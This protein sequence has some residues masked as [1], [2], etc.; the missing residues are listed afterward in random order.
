MQSEVERI[1]NRAMKAQVHITQTRYVLSSEI[2]PTIVFFVLYHFHKILWLTPAWLL[3]KN[4]K[5]NVYHQFPWGSSYR[6]LFQNTNWSMSSK[7]EFAWIFVI[8]YLKWKQRKCLHRKDEEPTTKIRHHMIWSHTRVL[9]PLNIQGIISIWSAKNGDEFPSCL[10]PSSCTIG[11]DPLTCFPN[12]SPINRSKLITFVG[13][14]RERSYGLQ[15][16]HAIF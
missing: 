7:L 15:I 6:V 3:Q 8:L 12:C 10:S 16:H 13:V 11:R 9:S 2:C 4:C 5:T 1:V 14:D